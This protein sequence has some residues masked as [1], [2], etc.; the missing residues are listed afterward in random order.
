MVL[1]S[2]AVYRPLIW[3]LLVGLAIVIAIP[4][5]FQR[6]EYVASQYQSYVH[7]LNVSSNPPD[8]Y[9]NVRGLIGKMGWVMSH[10]DFNAAA[11]VAAAATLALCLLAERRFAE[12]MRVFFLL[13][14]AACYLMVFNPRTE[15]NSYIML[16]PAIALPAAVFIVI[17]NRPWIAAGLYLLCFLLVC[18][19]WAY[20]ATENWLKPLTCLVVWYLLIRAGW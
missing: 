14:F 6:T 9:C 3:R 10:D 12:P 11:M 13:G 1:L 4:F 2:A 19:G 5:A 18:D 16:A 7:V 20:K 15:S 8:L 17:R